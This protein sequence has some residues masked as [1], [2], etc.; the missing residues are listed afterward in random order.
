MDW[1]A[2]FDDQR[3]VIIA[4]EVPLDPTRTGHPT[5]T[6]AVLRSCPLLLAGAARRRRRGALK[7][8]LP[9]HADA[10]QVVSRGCAAAKRAPP[11]A[12]HSAAG[13]PAVWRRGEAR[14]HVSAG[15]VR[16][17]KPRCDRGA[18][19]APGCRNIVL[20]RVLDTLRELGGDRWN[21]PPALSRKD[22]R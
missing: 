19:R 9:S 11:V 17:R 10:P 5:A 2:V 15:L 8:E 7:G 21:R 22:V 20:S 18:T 1:D 3:R 13:D 4:R 12:F 16:H 6:V 14:N